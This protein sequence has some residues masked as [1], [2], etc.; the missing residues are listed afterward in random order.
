MPDSGSEGVDGLEPAERDP[1]GMP[2]VWRLGEPSRE[3]ACERDH[4]PT[5]D[6]VHVVAQRSSAADFPPDLIACIAD[7]LAPGA[8][9]T[10]ALVC[11]NWRATLLGMPRY[12]TR[13]CVIQRDRRTNSQ[14]LSVQHVLQALFPRSQGLP[15]HIEFSCDAI[16][17]LDDY[18]AIGTI[19]RDEMHRTRSLSL[20]LPEV[21][22]SFLHILR[23]PAPALERFRLHSKAGYMSRLPLDLFARDAPRLAYVSLVGMFLPS[24]EAQMGCVALGTVTELVYDA[25]VIDNSELDAID[26]HLPALQS[27]TLLGSSCDVIPDESVCLRPLRLRLPNIEGISIAAQAF[28]NA[29]S[30][31]LSSSQAYWD[32]PEL[33]ALA[34]TLHDIT[35]VGMCYRPGL[36]WDVQ[37]QGPLA[38]SPDQI[39][40]SVNG[41]D[42]AVDLSLHEARFLIN[43]LPGR[44]QDVRSCAAHEDLWRD[45]SLHDIPDLGELTLHLS[46]PAETDDEDDAYSAPWRWYATY[47]LREAEDPIQRHDVPLLRLVAP[48]GSKL[49][50]LGESVVVEAIEALSNP[51]T[52]RILV[53]RGVGLDVQFPAGDPGSIHA[54]APELEIRYEDQKGDYDFEPWCWALPVEDAVY[55]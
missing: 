10:A 13:V 45:L 14:R 29:S 2:T 39:A 27:L 32:T 18:R 43:A 6:D 48:P 26:L 31:C 50:D 21:K 47:L 8:L 5:E 54:V 42:I 20:V 46:Y 51:G 38:A 35:S 11:G 55:V 41:I 25:D 19:I 3:Q 30:V 15:L 33:E 53:L 40:V 23:T 49:V 22:A 12:W 1:E 4:G 34:D 9:Y 17:S 16:H 37:F 24:D 52:L 7:Y 44:L 28:P 36:H